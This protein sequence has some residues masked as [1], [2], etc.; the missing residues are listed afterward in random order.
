MVGEEATAPVEAE[1]VA[2]TKRRR[3][4]ARSKVRVAARKDQKGEVKFLLL[5]INSC[6]FVI[7]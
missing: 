2:T 1:E 6:V 7:A 5:L 3:R 4:L